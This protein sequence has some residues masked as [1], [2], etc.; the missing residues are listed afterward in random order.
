MTQLSTPGIFPKFLVTFEVTIP[1][2]VF[3]LLGAAY[4]LFNVLIVWRAWKWT[5]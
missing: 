4:L 1:D 2:A 5:K 3:G